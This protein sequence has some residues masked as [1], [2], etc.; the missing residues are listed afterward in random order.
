[1]VALH[2]VKQG[3]KADAQP[4]CGIPPI[5]ARGREGRA[6]R[7]ALRRL[8]GGTEGT[9]PCSLRSHGAGSREQF[10]SEI[11]WLEDLLVRQHRRALDRML[12]LARVARPGLL[13]EP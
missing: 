6:D 7:L 2:L 9:A 12:Q 13:R 11:G 8:H 1:M 5:P 4:L 10:L 3:A